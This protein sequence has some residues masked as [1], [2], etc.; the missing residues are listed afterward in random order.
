MDLQTAIAQFTLTPPVWA[1][2]GVI[3]SNYLPMFT[4]PG[5]VTG[6]YLAPIRL[7][8]GSHVESQLREMGIDFV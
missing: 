8:N 3:S 2:D 1:G 7:D 6:R 5:F 4:T